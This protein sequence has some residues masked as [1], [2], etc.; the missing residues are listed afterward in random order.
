MIAF[1]NQT[2][3]EKFLAMLGRFECDLF[4]FRYDEKNGETKVAKDVKMGRSGKKIKAPKRT[5]TS[6]PI[7]C[8]KN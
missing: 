4:I 8:Q 2:N 3:C 5:R 1:C 7:F 6:H